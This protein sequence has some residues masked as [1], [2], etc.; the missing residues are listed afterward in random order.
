MKAAEKMILLAAVSPPVASNGSV[1][2]HSQM[3][4]TQWVRH[5][6]GVRR[7]FGVSLVFG[8]SRVFVARIV[9]Y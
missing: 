9:Q 7:V 4:V 3:T 6:C 5:G 2:R 8:V 1:S